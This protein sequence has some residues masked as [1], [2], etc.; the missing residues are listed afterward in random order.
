MNRL[1]LNIRL[2]ISFMVLLAGTFLAETQFRKQQ[3][4]P[5]KKSM[6]ESV[7]L[8]VRMFKVIEDLKLKGSIVSD[9][10]SN[11]PFRFMIGDEWS[12]ITTTLGS[13]EAKE[14]STN[15]DF[16]ALLVRL[17]HEADISK[18]DKV[19]VIISGSFPSLAISAL[20]ALHTMEVEA[21]VMSSPGASTYGANQPEATWIDMESALRRADL[22]FNTVLVS[23]GAGGDSGQGL[24]DE[25][26]AIIRN[27]A[28]RNSVDLFIPSSLAESIEKRVGIL[29]EA[30]ISL[31]INIGGNETALGSCPH[32][33]SIPNGLH[34]K[35]P[36]CTDENRGLI[37]RMNES[38]IP[39]INMLDIKDL[40]SRYG[41]DISPGT[42]YAKATGLYETTT[43]NKPLIGAILMLCLLPIIILRKRI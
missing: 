24:S 25:G 2:L 28:Y 23:I 3:P 20:A 5:F 13:L 19:G 15:P 4:L 38:G 42:N 1:N 21:V 43:T 26:L 39:F 40:A 32:S 36:V 22:H 10:G 30:N 27:A 29:V 18:G 6:T 16:S 11:V 35:L 41:I 7:E 34:T 8:T 17:L 31:L 14:I 33:L 9:A 37:A 12:A